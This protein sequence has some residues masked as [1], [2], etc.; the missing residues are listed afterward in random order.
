MLWVRI[1][2]RARCTILCSKVCQWLA[3]CWWFSPGTLVFST[4]KTDRHDI[5]EKLLKVASNTVKQAIKPYANKIFQWFHKFRCVIT[6]HIIYSITALVYWISLEL[7]WSW[8][9]VNWINNYLCNQ[10]LSPLTLWVL[11]LLMCDFLRVL[12]FSPPIKLTAT[13]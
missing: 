7:S 12:R 6:F 4:N 1:S 10:C 11:I 2:I 9:Y 5:T 13:I 3:T 8:S